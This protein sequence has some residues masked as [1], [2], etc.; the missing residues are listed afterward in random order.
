MRLL[1]IPLVTIFLL[2]CQPKESNINPEWDRQGQEIVTVSKFYDNKH[3]L[4]SALEKR[5]GRDIDPGLVGLAIM[6]PNDNFCE[7]FSLKPNR[8]DDDA[9]L[10]YG[11]EALHCVYGRYHPEK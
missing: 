3:Q 10:T 4:H 5:L 9:T 7:I 2:A 11:H 8:I 6:S 1:I